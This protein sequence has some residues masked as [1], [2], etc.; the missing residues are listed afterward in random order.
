FT[1][2][3]ACASWSWVIVADARI[4]SAPAFAV[5]VTSRAPATQ[6]MPVCTIGTS[7]PKR[8]QSGVRRVITSRRRRDFLLAEP[9]RVD[10][11]ANPLHFLVGRQ[12]RL[13]HCAFDDELEAGRRD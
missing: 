1:S 3:I 4:P 12:P 13:G 6:P 2:R 11:V 7:M 9:V 8:S 5:A 10:D